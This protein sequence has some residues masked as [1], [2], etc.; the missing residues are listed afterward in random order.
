MLWVGDHEVV[1]RIFSGDENVVK[2]AARTIPLLAV[3]VVGDGVQVALSGVIKGCGRQCVAAPVVVFSYW[4]VALP[5]AYY[6]S[7]VK[8]KGEECEDGFC[9]VVGLTTGMTVGT[10]VHCLFI[11]LIVCCLNWDNEAKRAL[12]V[13]K[14]SGE[15]A[16]GGRM[17]W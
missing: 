1:P 7:F 6:L 9:G 3:Y 10:W 13:I 5:I 2:S 15:G 14:A 16:G 4:I 17:R 8:F 12:E 11:L